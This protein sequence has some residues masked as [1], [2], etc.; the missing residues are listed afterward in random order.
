MEKVSIN[1]I[2]YLIGVDDDIVAY[3]IGECK[4]WGGFFVESG[5]E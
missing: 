4:G 3:F 1:V 5:W 2:T